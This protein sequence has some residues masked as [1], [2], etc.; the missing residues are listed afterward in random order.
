MY[1]AMQRRDAVFDGIFYLGVVT[2][3][4]FC[5]PSCPARKPLRRNVRFFATAQQA[6]LAGFRA[7]RRCRPLEPPGSAPAW[8]RPL[9]A[10]VDA[11]PDRRWR[12]GDLRARGLDP[13]RVRRWFQ[14]NHSMTFHAFHRAR[15]LGRALGR[16][17]D[18][19]A[20]TAT[21]FSSGYESMSGFQQAMQQLVGT[22]PARA[23]SAD[24]LH[25]T[26]IETPLGVMIAA[27]T[28]TA[29]AL[30]EFEDRRM[31]ETQLARAAHRLGGVFVPEP[32][33]VLA[34][35]ERELQ[36]Y[37]AGDLRTFSIP[38]DLRGTPFQEQVWRTLCTI[39]YGET[40]SYA[41]QA[42]AMNAPSAV[43]AVARAN[44]DNRIAIVVPCHR[45]IGANGKLTGYGGGLW[46]KSHLIDLERGGVLPLPGANGLPQES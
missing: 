43:R 45:V 16:L 4:I 39:P 11:E 36:R 19:A 44:G 27:A 28:P 30:L 12:D 22:T 31:L 10:A 17:R 14:N 5:R 42:A 33:D 26:R 32:N 41:Q 21:A 38:L 37:F 3:G 40:R 20:V 7:C 18:G 23:G 6:M 46:R 24:V 29:L 1:A 35:T 15:R 2:T 25:F 8:L 34:L 9:L 13:V